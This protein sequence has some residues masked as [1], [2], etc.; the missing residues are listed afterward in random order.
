M[1]FHSAGRVFNSVAQLVRNGVARDPIPLRAHVYGV[2]LAAEAAAPAKQKNKKKKNKKKKTPLQHHR[3]R[4]VDKHVRGIACFA[5]AT[6]KCTLLYQ[7]RYIQTL[8]TRW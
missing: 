4:H 3:E 1:A 6:F 2:A 5:H 7:L 8:Y